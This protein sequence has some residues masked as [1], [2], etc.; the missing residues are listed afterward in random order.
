MAKDVMIQLNDQWTHTG[1]LPIELNVSF[2]AE[3]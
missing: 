1:K 3:D 2:T